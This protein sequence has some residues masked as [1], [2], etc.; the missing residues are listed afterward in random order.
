MDASVAP[1]SNVEKIF[2][3]IPVKT[4]GIL[5]WPDGHKVSNL[6]PIFRLLNTTEWRSF[7]IHDDVFYLDKVRRR[8]TLVLWYYF[9]SEYFAQFSNGCKD[10]LLFASMAVSSLHPEFQTLMV[11]HSTSLVG[12]YGENSKLCMHSLVFH[13]WDGSP[14]FVKHPFLKREGVFAISFHERVDFP[15]AF[16]ETLRIVDNGLSVF[17]S[18]LQPKRFK[19]VVTMAVMSFYGLSLLH[20]AR[21]MAVVV[22][23]CKKK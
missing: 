2:L 9:T 18:L 3:P 20:I 14:M 6:N 12:M 7:S 23:Y 21:T 1:M 17:L 16:S 10:S 4:H 8:G 15:S 19:R 5:L 13:E 22:V 11:K